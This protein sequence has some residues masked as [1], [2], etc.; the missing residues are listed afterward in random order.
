ASIEARLCLGCFP[1]IFAKA[2]H[3]ILRVV[4]LPSLSRHSRIPSVAAGFYLRTV[5]R[6]HVRSL[7]RAISFFGFGTA[8]FLLLLRFHAAAVRHAMFAVSALHSFHPSC[9]R[10]SCNRPLIASAG[11]S[12]CCRIFITL[13]GTPSG[14]S[15]GGRGRNWR[16]LLIEA[17]VFCF[18]EALPAHAI[19]RPAATF[20]DT[21]RRQTHS[22]A[23]LTKQ[24]F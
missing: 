2:A 24:A 4:V 9:L 16:R 12:S 8:P 14:F 18:D 3:P 20:P 1:T 17:T 19:T 11:N 6:A 21:P 22:A 5:G 10:S 23:D 7:Q 13:R 15:D